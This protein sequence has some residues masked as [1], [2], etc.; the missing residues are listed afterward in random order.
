MHPNT[1]VAR[2][3]TAPCRYSTS[4][5]TYI[6]EAAAAPT[7]ARTPVVHGLPDA[8]V[9]QAAPTPTITAITSSNINRMV[10]IE[11]SLFHF[12]IRCLSTNYPTSVNTLDIP[13]KRG[14][15]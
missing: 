10:N 7:P 15:D 4:L 8:I 2:G 11:P 1:A 9:N 5:L 6:N 14:T 13:V 3:T 12:R